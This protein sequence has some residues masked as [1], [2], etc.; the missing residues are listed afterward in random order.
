[1]LR[2]KLYQSTNVDVLMRYATTIA[3]H[4]TSAIGAA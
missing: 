1:M 3:E 4:Y 2:E